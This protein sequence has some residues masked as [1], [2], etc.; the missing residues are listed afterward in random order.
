MSCWLSLLSNS[1]F[2]I[3]ASM[4]MR[5]VDKA[6]SATTSGTSWRARSGTSLNVKSRPDAL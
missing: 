4:A 3:R 5:Y 2:L 1:H 6:L